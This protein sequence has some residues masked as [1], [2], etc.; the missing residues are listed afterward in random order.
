ME[1]TWILFEVG[2]LTLGQPGWNDWVCFKKA[3]GSGFCCR[4]SMQAKVEAGPRELPLSVPNLARQEIKLKQ[5]ECPRRIAP[6][7]GPVKVT[8]AAHQ[9]FAGKAFTF[10]HFAAS[11]PATYPR[12]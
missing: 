11:F 9:S 7:Y 8:C 10:L 6:S 1:S 5:R 4:F 12:S 3:G 2:P